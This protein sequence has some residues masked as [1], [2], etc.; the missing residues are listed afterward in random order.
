MRKGFTLIELGVVLVII[1]VVSAIA[2]PSAQS[3]IATQ[4]LQ[5]V[6]WQIV[7]DLKSVKEDAILYQQDLNAY[8][9]YS[10]SPVE[11]ANAA[12]TNNRS[13]WFETYQS[14][15][16]T[17]SHYIPTDAAT[18]HFTGRMLK[19]NIVIDSITAG[20]SSIQIP[21]GGRNYFVVCFRSGAGSSFRGEGDWVT[22]MTGRLNSTLSMINT[23]KVTVKLREPSSNRSYY[24]I[25]DGTGKISMYGS[26]PS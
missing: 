16:V 21:T 2:I 3:F 12:N 9:D 18:A 19:Y 15:P 20:A 4:R 11:P 26:P 25:V 24:V 7:Q 10:N 22:A 5:E 23:S 14:D 8:F 1:M 13:Y 6:A 17:K